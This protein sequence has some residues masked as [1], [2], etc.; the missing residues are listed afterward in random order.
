MRHS[1]RMERWVMY[2]AAVLLCLVLVSFWLMSNIFARYTTSGT[3]GDDARVASFVFHLEDSAS[4]TFDL[5]SINEP[6]K[7]AEY[8]FTVTNQ[9]GNSISEV[10]EQYT[11]ELE[12]EGSIPVQCKVVKSIAADDAETTETVCQT[13][14]F[15]SQSDNTN[16]EEN[17]NEEN[18]S[19]E[20]NPGAKSSAIAV[21]ASQAYEQEYTLSVKWPEAYNDAQYAGASGRAAVTLTVHAEQID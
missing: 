5:S 7:T 6:G 20:N 13:N 2:T 17:N 11:I 12:A 19:G 8:I 21:P 10:A 9:R 16:S 15:S 14:N 3:G 4:K 18:N 1:G